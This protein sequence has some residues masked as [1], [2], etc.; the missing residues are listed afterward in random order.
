M[1]KGSRVDNN[2]I[3][4]FSILSIPKF[5][6]LNTIIF[7]AE[8]TLELSSR[9]NPFHVAKILILTMVD[10]SPSTPAAF[11]RKLSILCYSNTN[12]YIS[13]D[14]HHMDRLNNNTPI[15]EYCRIKRK[16]NIPEWMC[17]TDDNDDVMNRSN[18]TPTI[19]SKYIRILD[20]TL[21]LNNCT[22]PIPIPFT[23]P[24]AEFW[25]HTQGTASEPGPYHSLCDN[26]SMPAGQINWLSDKMEFKPGKSRCAP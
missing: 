4:C 26:L 12:V 1:F 9:Y 11:C 5:I 20:G 24:L 14:K 15:L 23:P 13:D 7:S 17:S 8:Y 16:N 6:A 22:S 18:S 21:F 2:M 25:R 10:Y 19:T 3:L